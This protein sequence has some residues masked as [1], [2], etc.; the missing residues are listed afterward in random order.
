MEREREKIR[1]LC[2][3]MDG[4]KIYLQ[5]HQHWAEAVDGFASLG[6]PVFLADLVERR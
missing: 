5:A 2:G 4:P 1:S 3:L 6:A